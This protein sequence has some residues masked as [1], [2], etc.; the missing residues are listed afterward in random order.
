MLRLR[1]YGRRE[2][3]LTW[4]GLFCLSFSLQSL[5]GGWFSPHTPREM[6]DVETTRVARSLLESGQFRDPFAQ[7]PTGPTAHVAPAYPVLYSIVVAIFGREQAGF[8]ALRVLTI[9][10]HSLAGACLPWLA[11]LCGMHLSVGAA[12]A[13][14]SAVMPI[15]GRCFKWESLFVALLLVALMCFTLAWFQERRLKAILILGTLW[16]ATMLFSPSV[17]PIWLVWGAIMAYRG[18]FPTRGQA[19]AFGVLPLAIVAPWL[20]RNCYTFGQFIFVRGNLGLELAV[21]NNDCASSWSLDNLRSGCSARFHPNEILDVARQVAALGEPR[22]NALQL[23]KAASW[24]RA[25]PSKFA[26]LTVERLWRFWFPPTHHEKGT[27]YWNVLLISLLTLLGIPGFFLLA[28]VNGSAAWLFG[29]CLAAFPLIH[30]SVQ[31]D[32][33]YRYPILWIS[34]FLASVAVHG[35]AGFFH[36][37]LRNYLDA[38]G[39]H[40]DVSRIIV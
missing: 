36:R 16:G 9:A 22:F 15:P 11:V 32:L 3:L 18:R 25:N 24:I 26:L 20:A 33:R 30:Y 35:W 12:A 37:H 29:G 38:H 7:A 27:G 17:T 31:I 23:E 21:S 40:K 39:L 6:F 34:V 1:P 2:F 13:L 4:V 19:I 28:R 5:A 14:V 10:A 8:L